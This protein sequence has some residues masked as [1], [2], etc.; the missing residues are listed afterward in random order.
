[1]SSMHLFELNS[2]AQTCDT[3]VDYLEWYKMITF[4]SP[5][6]LKVLNNSDV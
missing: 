2:L 6:Y 1:M 3:A 4:Y 5:V